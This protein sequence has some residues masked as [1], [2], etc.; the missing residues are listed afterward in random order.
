MISSFAI[1]SLEGWE[2]RHHGPLTGSLLLSRLTRG[3]GPNIGKVGRVVDVVPS[4]PGGARLVWAKKKRVGRGETRESFIVASA[5]HTRSGKSR[6]RR[7]ETRGRRAYLKRV[8]IPASSS[9][10]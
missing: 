2:A 10:R 6:G 4:K 5:R 8:R 3:V 1:D 7:R 9:A